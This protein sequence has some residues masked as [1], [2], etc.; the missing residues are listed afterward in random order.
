M[1]RWTQV[2]LMQL[3]NRTSLTINGFFVLLT[4]LA[5]FYRVFNREMIKSFFDRTVT[6]TF[7]KATVPGKDSYENPW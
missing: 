4:P 2:L 7:R 6:S 5:M 3:L 1:S